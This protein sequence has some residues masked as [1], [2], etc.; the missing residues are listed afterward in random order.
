MN[1]TRSQSICTR[2]EQSSSG[3][4]TSWK[5]ALLKELLNAQVVNGQ[6]DQTLQSNGQRLPFCDVIIKDSSINDDHLARDLQEDLD[7]AFIESRA[8]LSCV[9]IRDPAIAERTA[10]FGHGVF[11]PELGRDIQTDRLQFTW[12]APDEN[13]HVDVALIEEPRLYPS[14]SARPAAWH[15][16]QRGCAICF[17]SARAPAT[18]RIPDGAF[19]AS[20][21]ETLSELVLFVGRD[22][23]YSVPGVELYDCRA[24]RGGGVPCHATLLG[25][26]RLADAL[27]GKWQEIRLKI[28]GIGNLSL[29]FRLLAR[30][31]DSRYSVSAPAREAETRTRGYFVLRGFLVP[32]P[33]FFKFRHR[34]SRVFVH[35]DNQGR[36]RTRELQETALSAVGQTLDQ[37]GIVYHS[38]G[39]NLAATVMMADRQASFDLQISESEHLQM[40]SFRGALQRKSKRIPFIPEDD[41]SH[42]R[43]D[44]ELRRSLRK[45]YGKGPDW[46]IA[47]VDGQSSLGYLSLDE[48]TVVG[49]AVDPAAPGS[50]AGGI[51]GLDW[52]NRAAQLETRGKLQGVGEYWARF[53]KTRLTMDEDNIGL[54]ITCR[55]RYGRRDEVLK[56]R[57]GDRTM[58]GP[59][60][61]EYVSHH[62]AA[63]HAVADASTSA[64]TPERTGRPGRPT[65]RASRKPKPFERKL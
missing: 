3:P 35:F 58:L 15:V 6:P 62:A 31:G 12:T 8:L 42:T 49:G 48:G 57:P 37:F 29:W 23:R 43:R 64:P 47:T 7:T 44:K 25:P 5:N 51:I 17:S 30:T 27:M 21:V 20:Q 60:Y 1:P 61:V 55:S 16:G 13:D 32:S 34:V 65:D 45:L 38:N 14:E 53:F 10:Y 9:S 2:V 24:E 63:P 36:L 28:G 59:L 26:A 19:D 33:Q 46:L 41:A 54:I 52:L 56:V 39:R 50:S 18:L 40:G 4:E 11:A 22:T